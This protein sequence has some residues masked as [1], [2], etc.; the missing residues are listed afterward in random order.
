MLKT[1]KHKTSEDTF[2][3]DGVVPVTGVQALVSVRSVL[4]QP[5]KLAT[6]PEHFVR[7]LFL[8]ETQF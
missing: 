3:R 4:F 5:P 1:T 2:W 8:V 6:V 7:Y